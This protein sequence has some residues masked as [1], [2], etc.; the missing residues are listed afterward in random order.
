MRLSVIEA[1]SEIED[2][3]II[4]NNSGSIIVDDIEFYQYIRNSI[5][6]EEQYRFDI[7]VLHMQRLENLSPKSSN[8]FRKFIKYKCL[9]SHIQYRKEKINKEDITNIFDINN[10]DNYLTLLSYDLIGT[11]GSID[12]KKTFLNN[13]KIEIFD[14][15]KLECK[16]LID[17]ENISVEMPKVLIMDGYIENISN[18]HHILQNSSD[19]KIPLFIFCRGYSNDVLNT[20][21]VNLFRKTLQVYPF[22]IRL[23]ENSINDLY[24]LGMICNSEVFSSEKGQFYSSIKYEDIKH[25]DHIK[26]HKNENTIFFKNEI[27][28]KDV[29]EH[30]QK[31]KN[32]LLNNDVDQFNI[33]LY[34]KRIKNLTSKYIILNLKNNIEFELRKKRIKN[35]I[36]ILDHISRFGFIKI[37][38]EYYPISSYEMAKKCYNDFID[39]I[40]NNNIVII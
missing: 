17:I 24:D 31:L 32:K 27:S 18:I 1:L 3:E 16:C 4:L 6:K 20:L 22:Q 39:N 33:D 19:K 29:L 21:S 23:D 36:R 28:K 12:I 13:E 11:D 25:I 34:I 10:I 5:S 30:A 15:H 37:D 26:Y 38:D 35:N 14:S 9:D 40:N 7:S 2:K 8:I